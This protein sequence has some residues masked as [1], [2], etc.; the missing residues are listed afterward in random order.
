MPATDDSHL[1]T[2]WPVVV[3]ALMRQ[4]PP[5]RTAMRQSMAAEARLRVREAIDIGDRAEIETA[6]LR[7]FGT[8]AAAEAYIWLGDRAMLA[9]DAARADGYYRLATD[10][11]DETDRQRGKAGMQLASAMLG[12]SGAPTRDAQFGETR[13][14]V[15]EI[16]ALRQ[17]RAAV[18]V[19]S[20]PAVFAPPVIPAPKPSR[21]DAADWAK[22]ESEMWH[23]EYIPPPTAPIDWVAQQVSFQVAA[24]RLLLAS[25]FQIASYD[26]GTAALQWRTSLPPDVPQRRYSPYGYRLA[27]TPNRPVLAPGP[28]YA[29]RMTTHGN[30]GP[31]APTLACLEST[32][33]D[34]KW[35]GVTDPTNLVVSNPV[36]V[37]DQL[38]ALMAS[39]QKDT[40]AGSS[41]VASSGLG[42]ST[43]NSQWGLMLG[44]F[45]PQSGKLLHTHL[46][47]SL[48]DTWQ[49]A[50]T[51]QMT[52][53]ENTLIASCMGTV[54]C[55]DMSGE[56]LWAR[57]ELTLPPSLDSGW[58]TQW[59]VPPIVD[60]ELCYVAQ[61][62][63]H[64]VLCMES[65]TGRLRWRADVANLHKLV[66]LVDG[67]VIVHSDNG[68]QSIEAATGKVQ[69]YHEADEVLS[70]LLCGEPGGLLYARSEK[71]APN[72]YRPA[73]VWV[74]LGSG[75][76]RGVSPLDSLRHAQPR[77]GPIVAT[78]N[79]LL[80]LFGRDPN[81]DAK[82]SRDILALTPQGEASLPPPD[83]DWEL[84]TANVSPDLRQA[85][86]QVFRDWMLFESPSDSQTGYAAEQ[87]DEQNVLT[88]ICPTQLAKRITV[89]TGGK[90][91]L[92]IRAASVEPANWWLMVDSNGKR[93][94]QQQVNATAAGETWQDFDVDLTPLAGQT[95]WVV[96]RALPNGGTPHIRWS[97]IEVLN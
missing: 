79:R 20:R 18:G 30:G 39:I 67:R 29:W 93:I 13:L 25:G 63:V 74:D 24:N 23:F 46:L 40:S 77:L 50:A 1:L 11:S 59:R 33:G 12:R 22:Y 31:I 78:D 26:L 28:I 34:V 83:T 69:W 15:A 17:Q 90:P 85:A 71:M 10:T 84:W 7:Y 44:V 87:G 16:D 92:Q 81:P 82:P 54:I 64:A 27:A 86:T 49:D 38:M 36:L 73:L 88:T 89:P 14:S 91:R 68:F 80:A 4:H 72:I 42:G 62:G 41:G 3:E 94:L 19:D 48:L 43:T 21:Y 75:V 37:Q 61:P 32:S 97:R 35:T 2:S 76:Q 57:H 51:F 56:L 58:Q 5:W 47:A 55:F 70:A 96:V 52:A 60:G 6:A 66:G 65:K 45:D 53:L 8:D 9:A 95:I